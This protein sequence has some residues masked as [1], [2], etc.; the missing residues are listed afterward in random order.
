MKTQLNVNTFQRNPL[1]S[2]NRSVENLSSDFYRPNPALRR[3]ELSSFAERTLDTV[4]DYGR[5]WHELKTENPVAN[6]AR[7]I[8][9]SALESISTG[10][11][12]A[13]AK[14]L[15]IFTGALDVAEGFYIDRDLEGGSGVG[16]SFA[17]A[18]GKAVL[19][20]GLGALFVLTGPLSVPTV[21]AGLAVSA[22][23]KLI[24]DLGD[25]YLRGY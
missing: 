24:L 18:T 21:A 8:S 23:T 12:R 3:E 16:K 1:E 2:L 7:E 6:D 17:I 10:A 15:N 22:G 5:M 13:G 11:I 14:A 19:G 4:A 9:S 25:S 20:V